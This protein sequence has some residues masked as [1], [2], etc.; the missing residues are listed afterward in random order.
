MVERTGLDGASA[1]SAILD[2]VNQKRLI[3]VDEVAFVVTSLCHEHAG[4]INGQ[5]IVIDGGGLLA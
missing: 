1:L 5:P 3:S 2:T 4:G